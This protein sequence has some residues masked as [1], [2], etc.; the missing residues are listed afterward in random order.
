[1][2]NLDTFCFSYLRKIPERFRNLKH[3]KAK[4]ESRIAITSILYIRT[5]A[6]L[7]TFFALFVYLLFLACIV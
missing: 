5:Q 1:M 3:K 6:H 7:Q 2:Y 4:K